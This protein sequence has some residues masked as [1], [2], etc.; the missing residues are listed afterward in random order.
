VHF[1]LLPL[2]AGISYE[3][4][5]LSGRTRDNSL[6][7]IL[8]APGLWLQRITTREPDDKQL[9]VGLTSLIASIEGTDLYTEKVRV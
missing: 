7:R 3:L 1:S 5:K 4:L 8:I 9:E 6:T 2:V